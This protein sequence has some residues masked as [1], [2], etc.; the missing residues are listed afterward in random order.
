[1][2]RRDELQTGTVAATEEPNPQRLEIRARAT[3][4]TGVTAGTDGDYR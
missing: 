3:R 1:M 4:G 2:F